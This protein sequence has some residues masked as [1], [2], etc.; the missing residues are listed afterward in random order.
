V[1]K[2]MGRGG[3]MN[4]HQR[5]H[6]RSAIDKA[7]RKTTPHIQKPSQ[8][9]RLYT[10]TTIAAGDNFSGTR[11]PVVCTSFERANEI[12]ENNEGDIWESSYDLIVIEGIIPDVLYSAPMLVEKPC[13]Y[14]WDTEDGRYHPIEE[15]ENCAHMFG[16]GVG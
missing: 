10:I 8:H 6:Y 2:E 4:K 13:W 11:T 5:D 12:V 9:K 3:G 14:V 16:F 1:G 7:I 15:P